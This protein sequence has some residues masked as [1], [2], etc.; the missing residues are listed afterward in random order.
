MLLWLRQKEELETACFS[1]FMTVQDVSKLFMTNVYV[2]QI[3]FHKAQQCKFY[4]VQD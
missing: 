2:F 4:S 3:N 1:M